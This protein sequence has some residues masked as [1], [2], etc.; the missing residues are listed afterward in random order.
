MDILDL[1]EFYNRPLG[2]WVYRLI[3]SKIQEVWPKTKGE[4]V[5]GLGYCFPYLDLVKE[6]GAHA[7]ALTPDQQGALRWPQKEPCLTIL[8]Q[9]HSLPFL[10]EQFNRVLVVHGLESCEQTHRLLREIW[11]VLAYQGQLL[12]VVPNRRSMWSRIDRTPFGQG[13]PYTLRQILKVLRENFFMCTQKTGALYIPPTTSRVL[14]SSAP[15]WE[16]IGRRWFPSLPGVLIVEAVKQIY[17]GTPLEFLKWSGQ[18]PV[19]LPL[20]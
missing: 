20:A 19:L 7:I 6:A 2:K 15:T 17:A 14:L 8:S 9:I 4:T 12:L 10:D 1:K 13:H 3:G 16:R 11:R 5:L 18:R